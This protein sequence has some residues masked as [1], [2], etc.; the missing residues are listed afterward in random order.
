MV[1]NYAMNEKNVLI[2]VQLFRMVSTFGIRVNSILL[3]SN[4]IGQP[5]LNNGH[6]NLKNLNHVFV[7]WYHPVMQCPLSRR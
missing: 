2:E 4:N 3:S 1:N 7:Y 6:Y 5:H